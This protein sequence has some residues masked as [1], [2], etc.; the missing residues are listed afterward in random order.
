[1]R[2]PESCK[3]HTSSTTTHRAVRQHVAT[4]VFAGLAWLAVQQTFKDYAKRDAK[5]LHVTV[6]MQLLQIN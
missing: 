5:Q 3:Q 2:L 6:S 1:M 4:G